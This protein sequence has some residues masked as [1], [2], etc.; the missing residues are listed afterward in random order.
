VERFKKGLDK[1]EYFLSFMAQ[2]EMELFRSGEERVNM[3]L[4]RGGAATR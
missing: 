3:V 4:R 2:E 1:G